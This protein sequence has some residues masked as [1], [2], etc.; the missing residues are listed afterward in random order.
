M[1]AIR[2]RQCLSAL[3]SIPGYLVYYYPYIRTPAPFPYN[4]WWFMGNIWCLAHFPCTYTSYQVL[5]SVLDFSQIEP[6]VQYR[7]SGRY[8][9]AERDNPR[10]TIKEKW[11]EWS[12]YPVKYE[13]KLTKYLYEADLGHLHRILHRLDDDGLPLPSH[14][15][16]AFRTVPR[17]RIDWLTA[18]VY[19]V[20]RLRFE[21][22]DCTVTDPTRA[23]QSDLLRVSNKHTREVLGF[24]MPGPF[25]YELGRVPI[26]CPPASTWT[27]EE[28]LS[29]PELLS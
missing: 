12:L 19:E 29:Q 25:P 28:G 2:Y 13:V 20:E 3:Q 22:L 16:E 9:R 11:E 17:A 1:P 14:E 8:G 15:P 4:L 23:T 10:E 18:S 5:S 26:W 6:E 7:S 24:I 21:A 27:P